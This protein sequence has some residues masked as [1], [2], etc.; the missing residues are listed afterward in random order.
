MSVSFNPQPPTNNEY[1]VLSYPPIPPPGQYPAS[2]FQPNS[3]ARNDDFDQFANRAVM[4]PSSSNPFSSQSSQNSNFDPTFWD[5]TIA[6][7]FSQPFVSSTFVPQTT[8]AFVPQAST[9][10][11]VPQPT[12]QGSPSSTPMFDPTTDP[13]NPFN[14]M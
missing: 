9:S 14:N 7:E 3:S 4:S 11:F 5:P 6:S 2:P 13:N 8:S 12:S 10:P 1:V